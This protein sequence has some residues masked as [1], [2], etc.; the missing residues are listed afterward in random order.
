MK[1]LGNS[2]IN[3]NLY[4]K[5]DLNQALELPLDSGLNLDL[6]LPLDSG[7]KQ[8]LT[9]SIDNGDETQST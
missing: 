9:L 3:T 4:V 5:W 6:E 8:N 1:H 7:L 2:V